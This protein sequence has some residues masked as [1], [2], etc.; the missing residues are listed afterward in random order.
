MGRNGGSWLQGGVGDGNP[1]GANHLQEGGSEYGQ[2]LLARDSEL[3]VQTSFPSPGV[4][5]P[6]WSLVPGSGR[7][8]KGPGVPTGESTVPR[9][10]S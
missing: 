2:L 1:S 6:L 10:P 3:F 7:E 4:P 8:G 9:N 5:S